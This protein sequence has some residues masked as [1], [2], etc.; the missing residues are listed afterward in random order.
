M[1]KENMKSPE[2]VLLRQ[3]AEVQ[4]K[5]KQSEKAVPLTETDTKK[6][7]YEL[8]VHQIELE[9]QN[10]ELR[11]AQLELESARDKYSDLYEF[12]PDGYITIDEKGMIREANLTAASL[13][14]VER[15]YL[16][17]RRFSGF[18]IR[19][20]KDIYN[21]HHQKLFET[22]SFRSY[23]LRLV[24]K[25][26]QEFFAQLDCIIIEEKLSNRLMVRAVITDISERKSTEDKLNMLLKEKEIL[27]KEVHHR[28]KNNFSVV[29]SL[30]YL[31][32]NRIQDKKAQEIFLISWDRILSMALIHEKLYQSS[33]LIS[34]NFAD[35][36][37]KLSNDLFH[38]YDIDQGKVTLLTEVDEVAL[39]VDQ[40]IPCGL[41]VNELISNALKYGFP[42]D[43]QARGQIKISLHIKN[44][45][46]VE[47][48]IFDNG[49]GL[50]KD[51][52]IQTA[53]SLGLQLVTMLAQGQLKGKMS[54]DLTEGTKFQIN[55]PLKPE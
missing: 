12:A 11:R 14:G 34:I 51:F 53:K 35:Y 40:A 16:I 29:S 23:E 39:G 38:T 15:R 54:L 3:K 44:E 25:G 24:N 13:L 32:S 8:E 7:I 33:N 43:N 36:I 28:V 41:I 46:Q 2:A 1:K 37:K 27:L 18:I 42:K 22:E 10:D 26:W 55:F 9:M 5:K 45:N 17:G 47:L 31:Q 30:L 4:F 20:D 19:D 21:F 6:F 52:D 48:V 50:P 49:V